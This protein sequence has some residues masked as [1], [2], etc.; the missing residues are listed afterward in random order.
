MQTIQ[1]I[2]LDRVEFS[3]TA[4]KQ[5]YEGV[6]ETAALLDAGT[7]N[8]LPFHDLSDEFL[9]VLQAIQMR[10]DELSYVLKMCGVEATTGTV[11]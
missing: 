11:Q 8:G 5:A 4:L 2:D 10:V 3:R 1:P 7:A 9:P 6:L